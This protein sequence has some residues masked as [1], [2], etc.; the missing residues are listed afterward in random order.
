MLDTRFDPA[1]MKL[2]NTINDLEKLEKQFARDG[3]G[4]TNCLSTYVRDTLEHQ[5]NIL[6]GVADTINSLSN[7]MHEA[8]KG[9][10]WIMDGGDENSG[11]LRQ[12]KVELTSEE[13]R[14][15][16]KEP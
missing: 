8:E 15:N 2:Y 16:L 10:L 4:A 1:A 5:I 3:S 12:V 9:H 13:F 7:M 6:G 11:G 14:K